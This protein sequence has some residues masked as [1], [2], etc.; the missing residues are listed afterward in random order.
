MKKMQKKQGYFKLTS[1]C[2]ALDLWADVADFS[3]MLS[4]CE[5]K[6]IQMTWPPSATC[7]IIN[8]SRHIFSVSHMTQHELSEKIHTFP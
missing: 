8:L 3:E 5:K 6:E 1:E 7:R 4:L 2:C